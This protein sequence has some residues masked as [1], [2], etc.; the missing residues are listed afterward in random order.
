MLKEMGLWRLD[1]E[2]AKGLV[3][4][5]IK[6]K[7][8]NAASR[9]A[10]AAFNKGGEE[11]D[12]VLEQARREQQKSFAGDPA[13]AG[14]AAGRRQRC[15]MERVFSD[16]R[17]FKVQL[18]KVQQI[19]KDAGHVCIFLPKYRPELKSI[20]RYWG[21]VK[22]VLRL[23]C[24][25]SLTHMLEILP[26]ALSGV[27]LEHIRGCRVVWLYVEAYDDGMVNFL[28]D[29]ELKE[30]HTHREATRR[31]DAVLEATGGGK[32]QAEKDAAAGKALAASQEC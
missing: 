7:A 11:R 28:R 26:G 18:N 4:C 20:E 16:L 30:W 32:T 3:K 21:Y 31:E 27:P 9:Q 14:G 25:Y 22:H 12:R 17:A 29:R 19:F 15:C 10:I 1:G 6:C 5:C 8:D 13:T 23:H 2:R 24:E